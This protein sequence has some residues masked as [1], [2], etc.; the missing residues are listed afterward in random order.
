[1]FYY[2][3]SLSM[4]EMSDGKNIWGNKW[5]I[6]YYEYYTSAANKLKYRFF[7]S[8][9]IFVLSPTGFCPGVDIA[10]QLS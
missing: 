9:E 2:S 1:M 5:C 6:E 8:L 10:A 3:Q 4:L 7:F